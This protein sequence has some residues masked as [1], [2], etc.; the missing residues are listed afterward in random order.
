MTPL[1]NFTNQTVGVT[2]RRYQLVDWHIGKKGIYLTSNLDEYDFIEYKFCS[3]SF[4]FLYLSEQ[5]IFLVPKSL[6]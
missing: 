5:Y 2:N 1:Q 4:R 6:Y 3:C